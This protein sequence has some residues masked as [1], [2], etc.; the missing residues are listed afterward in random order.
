MSD[1]KPIGRAMTLPDVVLSI[2][3][4]CYNDRDLVED[5]LRSIYQ[6]PPSAA[7]EIILVDDASADGTSEM[8]RATFPEVRLMR[9][10]VNRHYA[11]GAWS[12]LPF[13]G[14][15]VGPDLCRASRHRALADATQSV[16][17]SANLWRMKQRGAT[18]PLIPIG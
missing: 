17:G 10:D 6:N 15:G 18:A 8:V 11:Y 1:L 4:S 7:Y 12:L 14:L 2:V 3:I 13:F 5:C 16:G 9:N